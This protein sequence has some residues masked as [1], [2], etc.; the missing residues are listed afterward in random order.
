MQHLKPS[1]GQAPGACQ[2]GYNQSTSDR[3][4]K[5]GLNPTFADCSDHNVHCFSYLVRYNWTNENVVVLNLSDVVLR[6]LFI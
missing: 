3:F 4:C 6:L 2:N 5:R 1:D